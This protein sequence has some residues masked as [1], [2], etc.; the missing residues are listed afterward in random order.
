MHTDDPGPGAPE[1]LSARVLG[2]DPGTLRAGYAVVDVDPHGAIRYVDC[3]VLVAAGDDYVHRIELICA[4]LRGVLS[5][6]GPGV[7]ALEQAYAG[8]N[9]SSAMKLAEARGAYRHVCI[10]AGLVTSEY[11][12]NYV[13][14]ALSGRARATKREVVA[15]MTSIYSLRTPPAEDAADA[16]ALATCHAMHIRGAAMPSASVGRLG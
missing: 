12:P 4:D 5:E 7:L 1:R 16:L 11:S 8:R 15:R 14:K 10:S 2:V 13:K 6:F 3:G 9:V